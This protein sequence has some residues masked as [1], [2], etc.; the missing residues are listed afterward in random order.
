MSGASDNRS[1]KTGRWASTYDRNALF[2]LVADVARFAVARD[3]HSISQ[4]LWDDS[5]AA[6]GHATAPSARQIT[7]R[8]KLAWEEVKRIAL[9]VDR[10]VEQTAAGLSNPNKKEERTRT[11]RELHYGL[12]RIAQELDRRSF[13]RLEYERTRSELILKER[14]QLGDQAVLARLIPSLNQIDATVPD[15]QDWDA[16]LVSVGLEPYEQPPPAKTALTL[17]EAFN[18]FVDVFDARPSRADLDWMRA[19]FG[20]SIEKFPVGTPYAQLEAVFIAD[21]TRRGLETPTASM[22]AAARKTATIP[23]AVVAKLPTRK[24]KGS[25]SYEDC[26]KALTEYLRELR[27]QERPS[28]R[29][30]KQQ[31]P[32]NGWPSWSTIT[33]FAPGPAMLDAARAL[34]QTGELLP[35]ES[36]QQKAAAR[37]KA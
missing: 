28:Q 30:Y 14:R 3:P 23:V 15:G 1:K 11:P 18:I 27:A 33:R 24:V 4:R 17:Q 31:A 10:S 7:T 36:V 32:A 37:E 19:R 20:V 26:V 13:N 12:N 2:K 6:A 29:H 22:T 34:L 9:D 8:L 5:R 21:R 16:T 35:L 25:V